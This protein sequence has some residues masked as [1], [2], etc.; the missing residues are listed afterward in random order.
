[1]VGA[2]ALRERRDDVGGHRRV[3]SFVAT[4][5][6]RCGAGPARDL[7]ASSRALFACTFE[8]RPETGGCEIVEEEGDDAVRRVRDFTEWGHTCTSAGTRTTSRHF[9]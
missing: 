6:G 4:E 9:V 7:A 5:L 8:E 3:A 1:E 2:V